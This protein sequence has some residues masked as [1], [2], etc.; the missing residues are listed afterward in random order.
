VCGI[1]NSGFRNSFGIGAGMGP[2]TIPG[3]AWMRQ[4]EFNRQLHCAGVISP[5]NETICFALFT[6]DVPIVVG[7]DLGGFKILVEG[8]LGTR[9]AI[10]SA[11]K[12][13]TDPGQDSLGANDQL[14]SI[15]SIR[16]GIEN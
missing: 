8:N 13:M 12:A 16:R 6:L 7:S 1:F 3:F 4:V 5:E 2:F 11:L 14:S 9:H 15:I 10:I